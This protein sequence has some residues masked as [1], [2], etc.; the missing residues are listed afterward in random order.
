ML[1][2]SCIC[3]NFLGNKFQTLLL[4]QTTYIVVT[5]INWHW[6]AKSPQLWSPHSFICLNRII[7]LGLGI[8]ILYFCWRSGTEKTGSTGIYQKM[9]CTEL[10]AVE[11]MTALLK[12][13]CLETSSFT[14]F[15]SRPITLRLPE[16]RKLA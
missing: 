11:R 1:L 2:C 10:L 5:G 13:Y 14:S 8:F 3:C 9:L 6:S 16:G 7:L 12:F 4:E 15:M